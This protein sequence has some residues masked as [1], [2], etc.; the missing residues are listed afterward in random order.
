MTAVRRLWSRA[1]NMTAVRRFA[2]SREN[3]TDGIPYAY[4]KRYPV[5]FILF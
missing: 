2:G 3:K 1:E 4:G 5:C